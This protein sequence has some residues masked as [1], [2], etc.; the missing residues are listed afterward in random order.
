MCTGIV[1]FCCCVLVVAHVRDPLAGDGR[2]A[3]GNTAAVFWLLVRLASFVT[4]DALALYGAEE[5]VET[6]MGGYESYV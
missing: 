3:A 4:L 1:D 5:R 6:W 2:T